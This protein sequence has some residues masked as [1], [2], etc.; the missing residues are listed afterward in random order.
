MSMGNYMMYSGLIPGRIAF[1]PVNGT[2]EYY[3][4]L[5]DF[6]VCEG[7]DAARAIVRLL[8]VRGGAAGSSL[9]GRLAYQTVNMSTKR[10]NAWV[11]TGTAF[12]VAATT[13]ASGGVNNGAAPFDTALTTSGVIMI[14]FGVAYQ[15]T[16]AGAWLEA[17]AQIEVSFDVCG[18]IVAETTVNLANESTS[19]LYDDQAISGW[20]PAGPVGQVKVC[21]IAQ[22]LSGTPEWV[23]RVRSAAVDQDLPGAW[24]TITG[25]GPFTAAAT[26]AVISDT[27]STIGATAFWLQYGVGFRGTAAGRSEVTLTIIVAVRRT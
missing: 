26:D 3:L 10:P 13:P 24:G 12:S 21:Y 23:F 1:T 5:T 16:A 15:A 4:A 2:D 7:V 8:N 17:E 20:I 22:G 18:Q 11:A 6:Y 9:K 14:R 19:A 25:G 27:A